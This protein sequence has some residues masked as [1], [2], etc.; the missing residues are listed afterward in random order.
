MCVL[1]Y[2][3]FMTDRCCLSMPKFDFNK[4]D[5]SELEITFY[6][7][8]FAKGWYNWCKFLS[9]SLLAQERKCLELCSDLLRK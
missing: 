8:V 2:T 4:F 6:M 1:A 3:V 7:M 9:Y 5:S